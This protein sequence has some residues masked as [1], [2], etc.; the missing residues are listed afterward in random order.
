MV[1]EQQSYHY[2]APAGKQIDD[3][4]NPLPPARVRACLTCSPY[5]KKARDRNILCDILPN[6]LTLS[7][8]TG[9]SVSTLN[10]LVMEATVVQLCL[11]ASKI[12]SH[13][14]LYP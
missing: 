4:S 11:L 8:L 9:T 6:H 2:I 3:T 1:A 12:S 14:S 13:C 7:F 5:V 10:F